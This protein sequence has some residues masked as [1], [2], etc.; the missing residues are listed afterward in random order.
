MALL[1][2]VVGL[3]AA[4]Y[5]VLPRERQLELRLR[6]TTLDAITAAITFLLILY[7][8]YYPFVLS[9]PI[10]GVP[11]AWPLREWPKNLKPSDASDLI[12][13]LG[14][15][16]TA[17]RM[18]LRRLSR[19]NIKEFRQLLDELYWAGAYEEIFNFLQRHGKSLL[20]LS[21]SD[22]ALAR[23]HSHL[24]PLPAY[25]RFSEFLAQTGGGSGQACPQAPAWLRSVSKH[26]A[27]W[28]RYRLGWLRPLL[29]DYSKSENLAQ[30]IIGDI[31]LSDQ[32]ISQMVRR[33]P[34][35]GVA[36]IAMWKRRLDRAE[37][38]QAYLWKLMEEPSS[39]FYSE[40]RANG[41]MRLENRYDLP[42]TSKLLA[43][44][45]S[46]ARVAEENSAY[47]PIGDYVL[48]LLDELRQDPATDPYNRAVGYFETTEQWKSPFYAA[49]RFFDIMVE[50]ALHQ[51]IQW[52]M[53]LYYMPPIVRK[54]ARNYRIN[55][56][57]SD[58]NDEFPNRYGYL[59]YEIF[60]SLRNWIRDA[61]Q[62]PRTQ[63]NVVLEHVDSQH[64]NGNIPKS[65]IKALCESLFYV[66]VSENLGERQKHS[67]IS[68]VFELF[69]ELRQI[70]G[71]QEYGEVLLHCIQDV[72]KYESD[73][74]KYQETLRTVFSEEEMEY[75]IT[76]QEANVEELKRFLVE[77][78]VRKT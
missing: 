70:D 30:S 48:M 47:K 74:L 7:C 76:H 50:E 42:D 33:R 71:F 56:P 36:L 11:M 63:A 12:L 44:F 69:F 49:I 64:E 18:R 5:A 10:G 9:H 1:I 77:F 29:P 32:F 19:R 34:Y 39:A 45:L 14:V 26:I 38:I 6:L 60:S 62:L 31:L 17:T 8:E 61:T 20:R 37:F 75:L 55:D 35:L 21:A 46:D 68:S 22:F 65:S 3:L 2:A 15:A 78:R 67:L 52:H 23:L 24:S 57:L 43:F 28:T 58:A 27:E 41:G 4:I 72:E 16:V 51:N 25:N 73:A 54:M 66:V 40:L 13:L 53:W 59:I